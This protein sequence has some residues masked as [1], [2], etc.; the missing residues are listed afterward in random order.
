MRAKCR[1]GVS[2]CSVPC[3]LIPPPG[4]ILFLTEKFFVFNVSFCFIDP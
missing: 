1:S 2:V 3:H 4:I